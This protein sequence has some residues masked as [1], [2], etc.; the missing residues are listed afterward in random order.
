MA[1]RFINASDHETI[2]ADAGR[3]EQLQGMGGGPGVVDLIVRHPDGTYSKFFISLGINKQNRA[4]CEVATN[5]PERGTTRK[6][7]TGHKF[8]TSTLP[9]HLRP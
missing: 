6:V 1:K 4:V 5:K 3:I 2:V 8:P 7:V 9:E